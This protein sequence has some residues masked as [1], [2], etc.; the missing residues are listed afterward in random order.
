MKEDHDPC[1][2]LDALLNSN[3]MRITGNDDPSVRSRPF[4]SRLLAITVECSAPHRIIHDD[5]Q[6][7][8]R[9]NYEYKL[10]PCFRY[11]FPYFFHN[12]IKHSIRTVALSLHDKVN[13]RSRNIGRIADYSAQFFCHFGSTPFGFW[14]NLILQLQAYFHNFYCEFELC[15]PLAEPGGERRITGCPSVML[16][17]CHNR[18][19]STH[20]EVLVQNGP[21]GR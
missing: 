18:E 13:L 21:V 10:Q 15:P 4:F 8:A 3:D 5:R 6:L 9:S 11:Q 17:N 20:C 1:L 14:G 2:I 16:T 12:F 19:E 7:P